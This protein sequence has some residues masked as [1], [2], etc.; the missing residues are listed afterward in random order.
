MPRSVWL[1]N[2]AAREGFEN[3]ATICISAIPSV[4]RPRPA[5]PS[6]FRDAFCRHY[7]AI[8][9]LLE[10]H[11]AAGLG[12]VVVSEDALEA[13]VWVPA[14]P[15]GINPVIVG[16]HSTAEVFLPWDPE[17]SLRHLAVIL[18]RPGAGL[19]RFRVLD[20]RTP[21]AFA[22]EQGRQL[23]ALESAGPMLVDCAS[24]AVMLFPTAEDDAPWPADPEAGWRRVPDRAYLDSASAD[25]DRWRGPGAVVVRPPAWPGASATTSVFTFPGPA[26]VSLS[27]PAPPGPARGEIRLASACGAARIL[28]Y[29]EAARRGVL[30]GR[31]DR[32]DGA[33]LPCLSSPVLSRVHLLVIESGGALWAI[34]TASKNGTWEGTRR[35]RRARLDP[36]R[37][38]RLAADVI[39]EWCP[40]H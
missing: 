7:D 4:P 3:G 36:G 8:R 15:D 12:L 16:R 1:R 40:F 33:F 17:L 5:R 20:L 10:C 32:C 28:L 13:T 11:R 9:E 19:G 35:I 25:P 23:E 26:F 2:E 27:M 22:D 6:S 14:E 29:P 34:D 39:L 21:N 38:L 24:F 31:Y 18:Q 37:Q 30:L